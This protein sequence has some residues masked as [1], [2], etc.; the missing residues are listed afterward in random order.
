M[1][2]LNTDRYAD[3]VKHARA[4][5]RAGAWQEPPSLVTQDKL[6]PKMRAADE[7]K[8]KGTSWMWHPYIP[9][10]MISLLGAKGGSCKG[11]T[12]VSLT[13]AVTI[14]RLWPDGSRRGERGNVLWC[15][16][17]DPL[18]EVVVPRLIAAGA[19]LSRV[20]FAS[21]EAFAAE[22]DLRGF[23]KRTSTSLIIQ[24]PMVSFLKL[25]DI[26]SELGVRDVLERLQ[27]SIE[28]L[29]C[30]V[31]GIAHT[32]KKADLAAVERLLGSVAFANFVRSVMLTASENVEERTF[33]LVHAKH[34]LSTKGDD[35]ILKP[36][37]VGEDHRDQYVKL[38]WSRPENGN[39][40]AE[41]LFDRK[42]KS[43]DKEPTAG[44]WLTAYLEE[45]GESPREAVIVEGEKAGYTAR[46]LEG[47][48]IRAPNLHSRREFNP[49]RSWWSVA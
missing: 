26:N 22:E 49:S 34:N 4:K 42:K 10:G 37:H 24:S 43:Q 11:L 18:P 9:A 12:C 48:M 21:R 47:A 30:S 41:A 19:D 44:K 33:R 6:P 32:N 17:E 8:P 15:E 38:Q 23:I 1:S 25:T 14:G 39:C 36:V 3:E 2:A 13:A 45:H 35:L 16:A 29:D 28:G 40:D 20:T 5:L 46:A 27:A 31:F 7:I